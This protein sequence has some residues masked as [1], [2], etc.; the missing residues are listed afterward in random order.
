MDLS[1][2]LATFLDESRELLAQME[3]ILLRAEQLLPALPTDELHALF[4]CAHTIKGSAG[5]F[6]L[7][8]VGSGHHRCEAIALEGAS[9]CDLPFDRLADAAAK[10]PSLQRQLLRVM[11]QSADRDHDHV[12]VLS[13]RQASERIAVFLHSLSGRYQRIGLA[14]DEF[15]LPM[16]RDEIARYLG[17][18]LETVSRAFGRLQEDG[19]IDVR[20][21]RVRICDADALRAVAHGMDADARRARKAAAR[22]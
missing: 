16:T 14:G 13:R 9:V 12:D 10:L 18:V 7:D 19:L 17:L 11:G 3:E 15:R 2:A 5:L 8:A 21:R 4:R 1:Q 22:A 20:G 6:G